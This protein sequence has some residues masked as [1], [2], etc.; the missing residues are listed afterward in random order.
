[1]KWKVVV[2]LMAFVSLFDAGTYAQDVPKFDVFA[3]YSQRF[4]KILP[5]LESI[6]LA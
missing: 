6:V 3:G 5:P 2:C 4:A 1:M